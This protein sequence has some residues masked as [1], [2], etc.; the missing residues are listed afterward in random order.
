MNRLAPLLL[1]VVALLL[2]LPASASAAVCDEVTW[3]QATGPVALGI[4]EGGLGEGHRACGRTEAGIGAGG[5]LIVDLANFYGRLSADMRVRGSWM[6][7][8]RLELFGRFE[9][10]RFDLL[11]TPLTAS[12]MGIGHTNLG[13][14][15]RILNQDRVALSVHGQVVLPTAVPL[16]SGVHP[17][18]MDFALAGQFKLHHK[19]AMH[20]DLGVIHSVG[21]GA[22]PAQ[23]RVGATATVGAEFRPV[24]RFALVTD[25]HA[26]F[27][28]TAPVDVVSAALA[29]R[30][31]DGKR[32][33]FDFGATIPVAGRERANVRL[34]F[35]WTVRLGGIKA[36]PPAKA[37]KSGP[38]P[39][40]SPDGSD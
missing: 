10:F 14:N 32:F 39:T 36:A 38:A 8:D 29:L 13:A 6:A 2:V 27:G 26:S 1:L 15:F 4:L 7:T 21:L 33:G 30:F 16:Y 23:P 19:V 11:I 24:P 5:M 40:P 18:A 22:G 20:A 35:L 37:A 25:L 9:F 28:Y 31:S 3:G 34:D 17:L 12:A